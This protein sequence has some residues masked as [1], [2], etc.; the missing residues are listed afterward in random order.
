[1]TLSQLK[2]VKEKVEQNEGHAHVMEA[3]NWTDTIGQ[4][5]KS[6]WNNKNIQLVTNGRQVK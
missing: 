6:E 2:K 3:H 5:C 4:M 1:V